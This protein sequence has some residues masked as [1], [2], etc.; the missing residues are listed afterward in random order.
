MRVQIWILGFKGLRMF[1]QNKIINGRQIGD[2][3]LDVG[4]IN[5]A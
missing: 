3:H 2:I 4:L 1:C 5:F